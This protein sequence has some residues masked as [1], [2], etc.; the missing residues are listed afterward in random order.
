MGFLALG[1]RRIFAKCRPPPFSRVGFFMGP[2]PEGAHELSCDGF[3]CAWAC[4]SA[5]GVLGRAEEA[6]RVL[7]AAAS[8]GGEGCSRKQRGAQ[9]WRGL[10]SQIPGPVRFAQ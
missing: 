10:A 3:P 5:G 7:E 9:M 8:A 4:G 1:G 6:D 2:L